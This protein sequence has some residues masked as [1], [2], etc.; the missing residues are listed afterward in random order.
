MQDETRQGGSESAAMGRW[1]AIA[2]GTIA[3]ILT[4]YGAAIVLMR[5]ALPVQLGI[6]EGKTLCIAIDFAGG[7]KIYQDPAVHGA[8][9]IYTPLYPMLLSLVHRV[10]DPTFLWG[11]LLTVAMTVATGAVFA[12][13]F[14]RRKSGDSGLVVAVV[15]ALFTSVAWHTEWFYSALKSDVMCHLL[16]VLAAVAALRRGAIPSTCAALLIVL[17]FFSKQT[18][19]FAVP[20]IALFLLI[21]DRRDFAVFVVSL[22]VLSVV[23]L[24]ILKLAAGDWMPFYIFGRM[25]I[26]ASHMFPVSKLMSYTYSLRW[27]P[28]TCAAAIFAVASIPRL[29]SVRPYRLAVLGAPFLLGGSILT[30][31]SE[32]G[33]YN[34]LIPGLYG[35]VFLAGFGLERAIAEIRPRPAVGWLLAAGLV[36]QMDASWPY[37]LSKARGKFDQDFVKIVDFLREQD[38]SMYC[39]SHNVITMLAGHRELDDR[40]L[41]KYIKPKLPV[42]YERIVAKMNSGSFDWLILDKHEEDLDLMQPAALAVYDEPIDF[43]SWLV[44]RR[45]RGEAPSSD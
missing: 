42:A 43:D 9:D 26:Q 4:L 1:A 5:A 11:R 25:E 6:F 3:T 22:G 34:S 7:S 16:W 29:W 8:A 32:G 17:A 20:G 36:L 18:A 24:Q 44:Y 37:N 30:A 35:L 33:G 45:K 27:A 15:V 39:P 21:E 13:Y 41:A 40:V 19:L 31:A 28:V 14:L 12:L 2:I 38:G 10:A 23:V